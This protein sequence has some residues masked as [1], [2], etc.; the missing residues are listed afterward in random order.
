MYVYIIAAL[1]ILLAFFNFNSKGKFGKIDYNYE[2][3]E[4]EK[5]KGQE[6]FQ[7]E[8]PQYPDVKYL[9]CPDWRHDWAFTS[10]GVYYRF[11][12][13]GRITGQGIISYDTIT[14]FYIN[15]RPDN[16]HFWEMV[17]NYQSESGSRNLRVG[18][19]TEHKTITMDKLQ[20]Y[21][22]QSKAGGEA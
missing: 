9:Y 4:G 19:A 18:V 5:K 15:E 8:N 17:I 2:R 3:M 10:H 21:I 20:V 11:T 1:F 13:D 6:R 22:R 16:K 14:D 12:S 7:R